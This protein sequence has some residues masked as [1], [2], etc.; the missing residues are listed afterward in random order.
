[1]TG[2][3]TC[4]LPIWSRTRTAPEVRA[5]ATLDAHAGMVQLRVRER[6]EFIVGQRDVTAFGL[7]DGRNR[8]A[9]LFRQLHQRKTACLARFANARTD[10]LEIDLRRRVRR[11]RD[12][13]G[14]GRFWHEGLNSA[15]VLSYTRIIFFS[16]MITHVDFQP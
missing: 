4:A 8:D 9:R 7:R 15:R 6:C 5:P 16:Y 1:M 13:Y 14:S 11:R 3:Q 2:V 10:G 12:G